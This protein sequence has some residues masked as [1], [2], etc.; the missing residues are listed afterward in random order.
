MSLKLRE[1]T[2]LHYN[3]YLYK[4]VFYNQL[5]PYFRTEMQRSGKLSWLK[6]ILDGI[7]GTYRYGQTYVEIPSRWDTTCQV[8]HYF[9]AIE[10][11]RL[12]TKNDDYKLR[13]ERA[14]LHVYTNNRELCKSMIN[15]TKDVVEFW[16]PNIENIDLLKQKENIVI[17]NKKPDYKYKIYLGKQR[18]E[19]SLAKWIERNP[20]LAKMGEIALEICKNN[21]WV[22]GYYFHVKDDK[23]LFL[24]QM[25]VGNNISRIEKLVYNKQ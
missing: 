11:Y 23:E 22:K 2:K 4:V 10:L 1:T 5:T 6:E 13:C 25:M 7:N 12:L 18:G 17:V 19:P 3:T 14:F 24:A 8:S 9:D 15:K 20:S 16:E 21:G